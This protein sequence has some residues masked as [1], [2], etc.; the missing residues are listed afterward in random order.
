MESD[1]RARSVGARACRIASEAR[2]PPVAP[3]RPE[4]AS[5]TGHTNKRHS[6]CQARPRV[7]GDLSGH[8]LDVEGLEAGLRRSSRP[9][10]VDVGRAELRAYSSSAAIDR[11]AP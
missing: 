4:P 9:Q 1:T 10:L 8:L 2:A 11:W 6:T 3:A 5:S 7:A